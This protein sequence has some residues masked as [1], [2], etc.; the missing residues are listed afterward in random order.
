MTKEPKTPLEEIL[1]V[2]ESTI[3]IVSDHTMILSRIS[4]VVKENRDIVSKI[5]EKLEDEPTLREY[6]E[7]AKE[8][9]ERDNYED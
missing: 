1:F 5:L 7:A 8:L 2:V 6:F 3:E 9:K 4:N